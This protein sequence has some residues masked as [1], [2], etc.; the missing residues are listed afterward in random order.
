LQESLQEK[1]DGL[2]G[3]DQK[4]PARKQD[5]TTIVSIAITSGKNNKR[6]NQDETKLFSMAN[7]TLE[8]RS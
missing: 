8:E 7:K 3:Q 4:K 6:E 2:A 1:K 5:I